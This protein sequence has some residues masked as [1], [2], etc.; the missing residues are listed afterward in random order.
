MHK[1]TILQCILNRIKSLK[2]EMDMLQDIN[3]MMPVADLDRIRCYEDKC[4]VTLEYGRFIRIYQ[5][6]WDNV[7]ST[8]IKSKFPKLIEIGILKEDW[9]C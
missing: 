2:E 5:F 9:G 1:T 8:D 4:D 6:Y 7:E 3:N